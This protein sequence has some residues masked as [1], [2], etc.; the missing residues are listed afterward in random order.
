MSIGIKFGAGFLLISIFSLCI[1]LSGFLQEGQQISISGALIFAIYMSPFIFIYGIFIS[2]LISRKVKPVNT[3]QIGLYIALHGLG[4]MPFAVLSLSSQSAAAFL[5]TA[6]LGAFLA[7]LFALIEL[8]LGYIT[9][10]GRIGW[11]VLY[12]PFIAYLTIFIIGQ[13]QSVPPPINE[14]GDVDPGYSARE[15]VA[16]VTQQ[17][18]QEEN[19]GFP[20]KTKKVVEW[21]LFGERLT[22]ETV[23]EN[24]QGEKETYYVTLIEKNLDRQEVYKTTY[25]TK[26]NEMVLHNRVNE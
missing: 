20:E 13:V 9:K 4:G 26:E 16:F 1:G 21:E 22:R 12:I 3:G 19:G 25:L 5:F 18:G 24:V 8:G 10:K 15:A 11:L 23:I 2:W 14:T 6:G 17:H 7:I